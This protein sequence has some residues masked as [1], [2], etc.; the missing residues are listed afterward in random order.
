M[1]DLWFIYKIV[2]GN[3]I[4]AAGVETLGLHHGVDVLGNN[5]GN[6][7]GSPR[8]GHDNADLLLLLAVLACGGGGGG[9]HGLADGLRGGGN[10]VGNVDHGGEVLETFEDLV[11]REGEE[12]DELLRGGNVELCGEFVCSFSHWSLLHLGREG[13]E[14]LE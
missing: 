3:E 7:A 9:D 1:G 12:V 11:V 10:L 8:T 4:A 6:S 5:P 14:F 13:R 2:T